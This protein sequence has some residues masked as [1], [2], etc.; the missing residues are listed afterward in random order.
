MDSVQFIISPDRTNLIREDLLRITVG[1]IVTQHSSNSQ[2]LL[3]RNLVDAILELN[4]IEIFDVSHIVTM[5][6]RSNIH[7][8]RISSTSYQSIV[9]SELLLVTLLITLS[10]KSIDVTDIDMRSANT[11]MRNLLSLSHNSINPVHVVSNQ[12][13][14]AT[15]MSLNI[16]REHGGY[17]TFASLNETA[18]VS[19]LEFVLLGIDFHSGLERANVGRLSQLQNLT[20]S[21]MGQ[22]ILVVLLVVVKDI[23]FHNC[24]LLI[25]F[26][27]LFGIFRVLVRLSFGFTFQSLC[28][29]VVHS[30]LL[31]V[32]HSVDNVSD[33]LVIAILLI[34]KLTFGFILFVS[35]FLLVIV[36]TSIRMR[37]N[38]RQTSID[39][40]FLVRIL[41]MG[42]H[43]VDESTGISAFMHQTYFTNAS[44]NNIG[45]I[46]SKLI[47]I[48]R[49]RFNVAVLNQCLT[50]FTGFSVIEEAIGIHAF[51]T[52]LKPSMAKNI[53]RIVVLVIPNQR[54]LNSIIFL[55]RI[56]ANYSTIRAFKVISGSPAAE[57]T[58][59][60]LECFFH[61][62]FP[63]CF[64]IF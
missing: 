5:Q 19:V 11:T 13:R 43:R 20:L 56:M 45:T 38:Q 27:F 21:R 9:T 55:K 48:N 31:F 12:L 28:H 50:N 57:I 40:C 26:R 60:N 36:G 54:N 53:A 15:R 3:Q 14:S 44:V 22:N 33:S 24:F 63:P 32:R 49:Q 59:F 42:E 7:S 8:L 37:Q 34:F 4:I 47:C 23:M 1:T 41:T 17:I 62:E 30:I 35:I 2:S 51:L 61:F 25:G 64:E 10:L 6:L 29:H 58:S 16:L 18:D 46:L 52:I 39:D